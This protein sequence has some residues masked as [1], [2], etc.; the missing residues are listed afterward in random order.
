[1]NLNG[2]TSGPKCVVWN[3]CPHATRM[4]LRRLPK[5]LEWWDADYPVYSLPDCRRQH[6]A[7]KRSSRASRWR[8]AELRK[9]RAAGHDFAKPSMCDC[10][11][12][13]PF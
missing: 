10:R 4:R 13:I 11:E 9:C 8:K 7:S 2:Q 6:Q 1:M 5:W 3:S 12:C